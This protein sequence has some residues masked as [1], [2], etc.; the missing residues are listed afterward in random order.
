MGDPSRR[1]AW[2][3]LFMFKAYQSLLRGIGKFHA[4]L[5]RKTQSVMYEICPVCFNSWDHI[6]IELQACRECG[7]QTSY[8]IDINWELVD[9]RLKIYDTLDKRVEE[10]E[11][12]IKE[13]TDELHTIKSQIE[14]ANDDKTYKRDTKFMYWYL[15][16]LRKYAITSGRAS[17][18]EFWMFYLI[19]MIFIFFA[20]LIDKISPWSFYIITFAY[21]AIVFLPSIAVM[22]RRLHDTGRSENSYLIN[23]IP[24]IGPFWFIALLTLDSDPEDNKYGPNPNIIDEKIVQEAEKPPLTELLKRAWR[25]EKSKMELT[26][27]ELFEFCESDENIRTVMNKYKANKQVLKDI[28]NDLLYAGAGQF[29]GGYYVPTSSLVNDTTLKFLLEYYNKEK[30]CFSIYDMDKINSKMFIAYRL[31]KYFENGG[32]GEVKL[33][34]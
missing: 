17:K 5:Y 15:H 18:R 9:K 14:L 30:K 25:K 24:F 28:Y 12:E 10:L 32:K 1:T 3:F 11:I 26:E 6:E 4:S 7:F 19:N 22:I 21:S 31:I 33:N 34:D 16:G 8:N 2:S 13:M 29:A 20:I 23:F 27:E